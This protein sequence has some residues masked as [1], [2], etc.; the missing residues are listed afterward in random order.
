[1][2]WALTVMSILMERIPLP[3]HPAPNPWSDAAL[4]GGDLIVSAMLILLGSNRYTVT[5]HRLLLHTRCLRRHD[6]AIPLSDIVGADLHRNLIWK[7]LGTGDIDITYRGRDNRFH[8]VRLLLV[9]DTE[10]FLQEIE[11]AVRRRREQKAE[12]KA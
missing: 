10:G 11:G 3:G 12:E 5:S 2:L 8:M 1:M 7:I 4:V 6:L 9:E